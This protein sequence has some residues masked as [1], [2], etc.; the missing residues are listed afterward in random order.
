[1]LSLSISENLEVIS[2]MFPKKMY[3]ENNTLRTGRVNEIVNY[4]Y[5]IESD[6]GGKNKGQNGRLS[7][8]SSQVALPVQISNL[9]LHDL[10]LLTNWL[11][12]LPEAIMVKR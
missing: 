10:K 3:F 8:L 7:I 2:L 1:V 9:F 6:L 5:L 4:I 12:W 11:Y